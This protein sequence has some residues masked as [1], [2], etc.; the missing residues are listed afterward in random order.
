MPSMLCIP[1]LCKPFPISKEI[2]AGSNARRTSPLPCLEKK[3]IFKEVSTNRYYDIAIF[4]F[5]CMEDIKSPVDLGHGD[6]DGQE[7]KDGRSRT[8]MILLYPDNP[9]HKKVLEDTLPEL[10]WNYAGRVHDKDPDT[11]EHHHV[12]VIFKD[13]RRNTDVAKDL[14]IDKRWLRAWDRQKKAFRY[15]CHKDN[16]EKFQYSPD[17]I[18]G[19][20]AEKAVGA[21]SKGNELSE[22]QSVHEIVKMLRGID[23][24][25]SYDRFLPLISDAGLYPVF[26]RMGNLGTR[27]V[28]E[29]NKA[30]EAALRRDMAQE[31]GFVAKRSDFEKFIKCQSAGMNFDEMTTRLERQGMVADD[32]PPLSDS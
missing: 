10:D 20:M 18:Y 32:L 13:G 5:L 28:D 7:C 26:R 21:C 22:V 27:L 30:A 6:V 17:G 3:I 19:T 23:G 25:I 9:E 1:K 31:V 14:G 16:P 4:V 15:L 11:K 12:V 2:C 29:H 8:W 24:F